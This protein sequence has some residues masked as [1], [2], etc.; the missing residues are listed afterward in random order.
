MVLK[1]T[2]LVKRFEICK[3]VISLQNYAQTAV[4]ISGRSVS[5]VV[6]IGNFWPTFVK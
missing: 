2:K 6:D 4:P 1:I 5:A 3:L